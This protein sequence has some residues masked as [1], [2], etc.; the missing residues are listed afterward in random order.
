ENHKE[1]RALLESVEVILQR[2]DCYS[3]K[4]L[5]VK[6]SDLLD[7]G[8]Q[9]IEVGKKL[10]ELLEIV[11]HDPSLNEKDYLLQKSKK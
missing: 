11:L 10:Q 8:Y 9:G 6:G 3:L 1:M 7:L 5:A 2:G 4:Q